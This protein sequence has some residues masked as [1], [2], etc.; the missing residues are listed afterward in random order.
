MR[1]L[2]ISLFLCLPVIGI[3][4]HQS[5]FSQYYYNKFLLNPAYAGSDKALNANLHQRNQWVGFEGAPN[6]SF[7]GVHSP[8][9]NDNVGLGVNYLN[10][11]FGTFRANR[12]DVSYSYSLDIGDSRLSFGMSGGIE[13]LTN[14]LS[15]VNTVEQGDQVFAASEQFVNP[16]FAFGLAFTSDDWFFSFSMPTLM[17]QRLGPGISY[18]GDNVNMLIHA[19]KSFVLD[20]MEEFKLKSFFTGRIHSASTMQFDIGAILEYQSMFD[21]GLMLRTQE[22]I[23]VMARVVVPQIPQLRVGYSYDITTNTLRQFSN[24][25]HEVGI[26]YVFL[27]KVNAVNPAT[28]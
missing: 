11:R 10:E 25:T 21:F 24:G 2:Y 1:L 27:Y 14:G 8:M 6:S 28:F 7:I 19:G 26:S 20:R 18:R 23:A 4:Q 16:D 17:S 5:V 15:D 12:L 9:K 3:A 13:H 22:S